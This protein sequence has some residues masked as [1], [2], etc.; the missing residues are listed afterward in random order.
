MTEFSEVRY[1]R[2]VGDID[3]AYQTAGSG[4][5]DLVFVSGFTSHLD[6]GWEM[7]FF[8]WILRWD[9]TARIITFDKRGTGLSDR[10]LGFGSVAERA[11]DIRAV[12]DAAG[13]QR[14]AL[15]GVSEGGPLCLLFAATY[16]E[17][18]SHLL[19]YGSGARFT[20]AVDYPYGLTAE[21]LEPVF[22]AVA[23]TWG[24]GEALR[25]FIQG[26]P[27]NTR[28]SAAIARF[29]RAACTPL[30]MREIM[31]RNIEI[32]VR[33]ILPTLSVP[34]LVMHNVGDPTIIVEHG[35]YLAEHI[36][37]SVY[38]EGT[39]RCHGNWDPTATQWVTDAVV[40]FL[41]GRRNA[42]SA[43]DRV[44]ATVLFTDIVRSTE[45]TAAVG[46]HEW[47]D[48]LDRHDAIARTQVDRW[49]G[50]L[51]K[52]TG[53]GILATFDGPGRAI[54]CAQE[55]A[56]QADVLGLGLRAG[57]HTGEIERRGD[58][59]TG[60]GVVIAR[61]ICDMAPEG[62]LLASRTV[63]DLVTGSGTMFAERGTHTLKGVPAEWQLFAVAGA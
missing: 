20:S 52:T 36:P 12:M 49:H 22:D 23:P 6:L 53:D 61:R 10:S 54:A 37:G 62:E 4:P 51:V 58:D 33:S 47:R 26:I 2:S 15:F 27:E 8:N 31:Q 9:G 48:L 3:I 39:G 35:R 14:A 28:V 11:D 60:L 57:L 59:I 17:R 43:L 24:K 45:R 55:M 7:P 21:T 41:G 29:E 46:D 63:K 44:L 32:D 16:P 50:R 25:I 13:V 42:A 40:D 38:V 34:T 30:M 18:V 5:I 56:R 19:L 1:A